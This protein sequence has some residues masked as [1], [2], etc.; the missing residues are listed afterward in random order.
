MSFFEARTKLASEFIDTPYVAVDVN[1]GE[2]RKSF[3]AHLDSIQAEINKLIGDR[4][5]PADAHLATIHHTAFLIAM[6]EAKNHA[7]KYILAARCK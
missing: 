1:V 2:F 7:M 5:V 4:E 6:D 3:Q